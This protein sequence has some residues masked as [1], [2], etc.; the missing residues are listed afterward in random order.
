MNLVVTL[1]RSRSSIVMRAL[2]VMGLPVKVDDFGV[3]VNEGGDYECVES[4]HGINTKDKGYPPGATIKLM[5]PA[6]LFRSKIDPTAR[7]IFL[8]RSPAGVVESQGRIGMGNPDPVI[9]RR[10]CWRLMAQAKEWFETHT[11]PLI[12]VDTD[13]MLIRPEFWLEK[14]ASFIGADMEKVSK[15]ASLIQAGK[16]LTVTD[17]SQDPAQTV[18]QELRAKCYAAI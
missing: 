9:R 17:E 6:F 2:S 18:Y 15:A 10:N 8:L 1:A 12:I 4:Q 13:D 16:S 5:L 7:L 11:N 14:I 3:S